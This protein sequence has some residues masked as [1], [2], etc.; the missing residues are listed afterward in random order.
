MKS[1]VTLALASIL[2]VGSVLVPLPHSAALSRSPGPP[3]RPPFD[4]AAASAA[5][6]EHSLF[7]VAKTR[8]LNR[9][10]Y[11]VALIPR[12]SYPVAPVPISSGYGPRVCNEGP[13]STFHR[14]I[15][16]AA[17]AGSAVKSPAVG[18]VTFAGIDGDYGNKIVIEH[19]VNGD[20]FTTVYGH[21]LDGSTLV[22]PGQ[23]VA[24][25]ELLAQVGNTG[26]SYGAHL[27]FEI[28]VPEVGPVNPEVWFAAHEILPF[29]Q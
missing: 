17:A 10:S 11:S 12:I 4:I 28:R 8:R 2:I 20:V 19:D 27:H 9:Q 15:D 22:Q 3:E 26:N 14:G 7:P 24:R 6:A 21:L 18:T 13:C 25:G 29:P 5:P 1:R 23:Q 16:Y